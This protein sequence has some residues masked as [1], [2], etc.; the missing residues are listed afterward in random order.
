MILRRTPTQYY[1]IVFKLTRRPGNPISP[2][3][4]GGPTG[5]INKCSI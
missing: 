1:I 5:P 3:G 4:P 2:G